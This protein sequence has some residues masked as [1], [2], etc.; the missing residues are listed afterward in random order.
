MPSGYIPPAIPLADRVRLLQIALSQRIL[1]PVLRM[2]DD[3]IPPSRIP[4]RFL[5]EIRHLERIH[6]A[7]LNS[8]L[9]PR[10]YAPDPSSRAAA[11]RRLRYLA[12][13][14]QVVSAPPRP[15]RRTLDAG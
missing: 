4:R 9:W 6:H 10:R 8:V 13:L 15:R 7:E 2:L 3:G 5:T 11:D 1:S 14:E 12:A